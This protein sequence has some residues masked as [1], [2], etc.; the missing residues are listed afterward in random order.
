MAL[1]ID[2][3]QVSYL[4]PTSS[5]VN[6]VKRLLNEFR[7]VG[8]E[9]FWSVFVCREDDGQF[10]SLDRFYGA[11]FKEVLYTDADGEQVLPELSPTEDEASEKRL[12]VSRSLDM[13]R[14]FN[15][16]E[17][18]SACSIDTV[19]IVGMWT[20]H[21]VTATAFSAMSY[22]YDVVVVSD[23]TASCSDL[24]N[25]ALQLLG[26]TVAKVLDTSS[27]LKDFKK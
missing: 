15:L 13:F 24:H 16:D 26:S 14:S 1:L 23:A 25:N 12:H 19:V 7:G 4:S 3:C 9:I 8:A 2:D 5:I 17:R 10:G 21:C 20:D 27:V 11:R 22:G 6:N 18:L